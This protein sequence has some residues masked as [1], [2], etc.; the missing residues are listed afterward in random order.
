MI[1]V[2]M[3]TIPT[4][5]TPTHGRYLVDAPEHVRAAG[6]LIGFHGYGEGAEAQMARLRAV[7][8]AENWLLVSVQAL[9]RFYRGRG[10]EVIAMI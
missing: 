10:E 7:P 9:N 5:A 4:I 8:G 6:L 2:A 1:V 3:P